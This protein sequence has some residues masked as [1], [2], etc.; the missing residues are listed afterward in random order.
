[1]LTQELGDGVAGPRRRAERGQ[2]KSRPEHR[3]GPTATGPDGRPAGRARARLAPSRARRWWS[4]GRAHYRQALDG[5]DAV[6]LTSAPH[7]QPAARLTPSLAGAGPLTAPEAP[8]KWS[9][10]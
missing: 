10:V 3:A 6:N 5:H 8:G 4:A 9:G 1:M 2:K 7:A